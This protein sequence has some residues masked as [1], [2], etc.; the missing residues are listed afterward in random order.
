MLNIHI[1]T[2]VFMVGKP[3]RIKLITNATVV[4]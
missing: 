4:G 1:V 3:R 2:D